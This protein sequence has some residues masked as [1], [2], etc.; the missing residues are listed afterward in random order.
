MNSKILAKL[1]ALDS[2]GPPNFRYSSY[3]IYI[4]LFFSL[5]TSTCN[6]AGTTHDPLPVDEFP[7]YINMVREDDYKTLMEDYK[8][9]MPV[10]KCYSWSI[11]DTTEN[12]SKN[13]Y[14]NICAYDHSRIILKCEGSE[15]TLSDYINANSIY[16][17]DYLSFRP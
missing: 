10:G 8:N 12:F 11:S 5:D 14:T 3:L 7:G 17:S 16:V 15:R 13:R 6:L 2:V 4:R 9:Q 1:G